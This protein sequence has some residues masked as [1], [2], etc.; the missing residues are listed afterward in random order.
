MDTMMREHTC[1]I[2]DNSFIA[3]VA[4]ISDKIFFFIDIAN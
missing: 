3:V 4:G 2:V 1:I